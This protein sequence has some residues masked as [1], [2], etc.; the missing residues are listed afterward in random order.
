MIIFLVFL[1]FGRFRRRSGGTTRRCLTESLR[2]LLVVEIA[3]EIMG[4]SMRYAPGIVSRL[5][6]PLLLLLPVLGLACADSTAERR[7]DLPPLPTG[8]ADDY[9]QTGV[10]CGGWPRVAIDTADYVCAGLVAGDDGTTFSPRTLVELPGRPFELLVTDLGAWTPGNGGLW[11]LDART[12]PTSRLVRV[13]DGLSVPHLVTVGPE[14]YV[15]VG[16][17][18]RIF[19]F[20]ASAV[21]PTGRSTTHRSSRSS[22]ACHRWIETG[23]A[24]VTTHS[25]TS[26]S[27]TR[28]TCI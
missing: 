3:A 21:V 23:R 14:D 5:L 25:L 13:L 7:E 19:A 1:L 27:T 9:S 12:P 6:S 10:S 8:K 22:T 28:A 26:S 4:A 24:T 15:F 2:D 18:T 20:P 17:D 16:E 11:Y